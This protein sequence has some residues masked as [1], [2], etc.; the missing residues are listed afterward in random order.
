M[1]IFFIKLCFVL[2]LFLIVS[3]N[4]EV[5]AVNQVKLQKQEYRSESE[6]NWYT[7]VR[8][9]YMFLITWKMEQFNEIQT[10][11][12]LLVSKQIKLQRAKSFLYFV[13]SWPLL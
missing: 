11:L 3:L 5:L 9:Q 4:W 10:F 12:K 8:Q 6:L 2:F 13:I 1:Y 7:L